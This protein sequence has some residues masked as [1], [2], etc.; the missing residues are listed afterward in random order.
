MPTWRERRQSRKEN[1]STNQQ[2]NIEK[3]Y[4]QMTDSFQQ[5]LTN[6]PFA[7]PKPNTQAPVGAVSSFMKQELVDHKEAIAAANWSTK[8]N[9]RTNWEESKKK[10]ADETSRVMTVRRNMGKLADKAAREGMAVEE[11]MSTAQ[12]NYLAGS[13]EQ[14]PF[15]NSCNSLSC[16]IMSMSGVTTSKSG[17]PVDR[18]FMDKE[19]KWGANKI[20]QPGSKMGIVPGNLNFDKYAKDL[21]WQ[22][23]P[24]GTI[25]NQPG[26]LARMGYYSEYGTD[27]SSI[28]AGKLE[29][30]GANL[31]YNQGDINRGIKY[32]DSYYTRPEAYAIG[33][34]RKI[35]VMRYVGDIPE[36]TKQFTSLGGNLN[37][38]ENPG[39]R[40]RSAV[41]IT[42]ESA[43]PELQT[44]PKPTQEEM[45]SAL[46]AGHKNPKRYSKKLKRQANK[47]TL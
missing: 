27:H 22:I 45:L 32:G 41:K 3:Q 20:L 47:F 8:F 36:Y 29:G 37:V 35:G 25:A 40:S 1:K 10:L 42:T 18:R 11:F 17:N 28:S 2:A 4:N 38:P 6:S 24:E 30:G 33:D 19:G 16:G 12:S 21:G 15:R 23:Q 9:K 44:L 13:D 43:K 31:V 34:D 14:N 26:D 39:V 5:I 46:A 7:K